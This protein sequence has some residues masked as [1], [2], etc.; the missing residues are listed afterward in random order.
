MPA[1]AGREL[2]HQRVEEPRGSVPPRSA[3]GS[4]PERLGRSQPGEEDHG[5]LVSEED[6]GA[7]RRREA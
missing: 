2:H 4:W 3:Q 5:F 6:R 1:G 7:C